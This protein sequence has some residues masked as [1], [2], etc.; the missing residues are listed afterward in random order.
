MTRQPKLARHA[1][2]AGSAYSGDGDGDGSLTS[3]LQSTLSVMASF[4]HGRENVIPRMFS[5]LLQRWNIAERQA[6]MFVYYLK[7]HIEVDGESHGPMAQ[8]IIERAMGDDP[9]LYHLVVHS[10]IESMKARIALWDG[11]RAS[12]RE[13]EA[14]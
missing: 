5:S 2:A 12:M 8:K 10:A 4:F 9:I 7:R 14:A 3:G 6:P 1:P 13:S 11:V